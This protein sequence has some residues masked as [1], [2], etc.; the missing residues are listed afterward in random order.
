MTMIDADRFCCSFAHGSHPGLPTGRNGFPLHSRLRYFDL[1]AGRPGLPPAVAALVTE[2]TA[3]AVTV[4]LVN[5]N[6]DEPATVVVQGGAYGEH[7]LLSAALDGGAAVPLHGGGDGDDGPA[8]SAAAMAV[9]LGP[10]T[11]PEPRLL[12][13]R[14]TVCCSCLRHPLNT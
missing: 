10:T 13:W 2:L 6:P 11:P 14:S 12:S 4:E 9:T 5:L 1:A 8:L 7:K 3:D